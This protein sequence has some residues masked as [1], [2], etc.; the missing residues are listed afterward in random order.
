[1]FY[2]D[3]VVASRRIRLAMKHEFVVSQFTTFLDLSAL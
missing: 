2:G 1:M 3:L